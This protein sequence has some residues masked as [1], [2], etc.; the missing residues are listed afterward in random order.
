MGAHGANTRRRGQAMIETVVVVLLLSFVFLGLFQFAE[1]FTTR[2]VLDHAA[3]RAARARAVGFNHF[4]VEKT[5]RVAT[6]PVAGTRLTPSD[7]DLGITDDLTVDAGT[8]GMTIDRA[9]SMSAASPTANAELARVPEYLASTAPGYSRGILD[10]ELWDA[11][12]ID[13]SENTLGTVG[14]VTATIT[15]DRPLIADF[16]D[17]EGGSLRTDEDDAGA[18]T[19]RIEGSYSVES[20]YPLYMDDAGL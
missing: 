4:M 7:A 10:Y 1:L 16:G 5:A 17:V 6:I 13:F 9:L 8:I 15:Q 11:M 12:D 14:R 19:A 3:A 20:H 2:I 18:P